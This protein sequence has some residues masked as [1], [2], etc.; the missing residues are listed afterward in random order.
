M[1]TWFSEMHLSH[2]SFSHHWL[3][4]TFLPSHSNEIFSVSPHK[5]RV[6]K[7]DFINPEK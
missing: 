7:T 4:L 2:L 3:P 1:L 6:M 5:T